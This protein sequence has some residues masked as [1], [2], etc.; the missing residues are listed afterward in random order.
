MLPGQQ[1][2]PAQR[3]A[4]QTSCPAKN[5][6]DPGN[7]SSPDHYALSEDSALKLMEKK[8]Y[9]CSNISVKKRPATTKLSAI[10]LFFSRAAAI[11]VAAQSAGLAMVMP[12]FTAHAAAAENRQAEQPH[13]T[14]LKEV[15][16]PSAP[17]LPASAVVFDPKAPSRTTPASDGAGYLKTVPGFSAIRNGGTNGDPVFRGMF[18]S[19]LNI[20][21]NGG[22]ILGGCGGRMDNPASYIF[23]EN[24]DCVTVIKGPQT[25]RWGPAGSAG[26]ILFEHDPQHF[27]H[28]TTRGEGSILYGTDGHFDTR[29]DATA[30]SP[31]GYARFIGNKSLAQDYHD[32]DGNRIP[33]KWEKWNS[34]LFIGWTPDQD[35]VLK[36]G[37]GGGDG[38]AR[39]AGRGMDGSRFRRESLSA[40]FVKSNIGGILD[41][42]EGQLYYNY[43]DH[44]MDNFR[45]RPLVPAMPMESEPDR[46]TLGG[47]LALTWNWNDFSLVSGMDAQTNTHRTRKKQHMRLGSGWNKDATFDNYGI[48]GEL[49]WSATARQRIITGLRAD[50]TA[51]QDYRAASA[52]RGDKR[53]SILPGAFVRYED[54]LVDIPATTYIGI[55]YTDRFPDY[56]ELFSPKMADSRFANAFEGIKPEQ[57]TQIDFGVQYADDS[58]TLW[59]SGY[60]GRIHDYILFDYSQGRSRAVNIDADIAGA[61]AGISRYLEND[62]KADAAL[63]YAWGKNTTDKQALPQIPPLEARL[64]LTY[65]QEKWSIGVLW[66][67]VAPQS[68]I[69]KN[70]GNVVGKDYEKSPGFGV[71]SL[72][73]SYKITDDVRI[74]GGVDNLFNKE[75]K[76]HLNRDG[77]AGFGFPAHYQV[78]EPGRTFW[79]RVDFKF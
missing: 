35:T 37:A 25:V 19:R 68:R 6:T 9:P 24:Y 22:V 38:N 36:L 28:F 58:N 10:K 51:V 1:L 77:D 27:D 62:W 53:S 65:E 63:A 46:R 2:C 73:G 44:I 76:E 13:D 21:T 43:A 41:K 12:F 48:F 8:M 74:T 40:K 70:K 33:S 52:T 61:E 5:Q 72:N 67:L 34:D 45:L 56:W 39:Y 49:T 18:G 57:T 66:R 3:P 16:I 14:V 59:F 54:D 17:Q 7:S 42:V 15:V 11:L 69:A 4:R 50:K 20:I 31:S 26:T 23:P 60:A 71:V 79:T 47:R 32:G 64:G 55:G 78:P 75:Y 30:G 29:I